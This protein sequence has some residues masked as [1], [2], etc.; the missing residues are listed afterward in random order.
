MDVSRN[1]DFSVNV[2]TRY[3]GESVVERLTA[4]TPKEWVHQRPIRGGGVVDY[5]P[6][7]YFIERLNECFGFLWS[8]RVLDFKVNENQIVVLGEVSV[9]VPGRT[10][11]REF[12]DGTRE[13]IKFDSVKI[14]KQQFGGAEIKRFSKDDPKGKYKAGDVIDLAD[15][16]KA[17]ATDAMKKCGTQFGMFLDVYGP[18]EAASEAKVSPSQLE[19][20]RLRGE[21]AGMGEEQLQLWVKEQAGK[22]IEELDSFDIM[23]LLPKL[24]DLEKSRPVPGVS[25]SGAGNQAPIE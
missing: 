2:K 19:A 1:E 6:G 25:G 23:T 20:L 24:M 18:R 17:A 16:F 5:V 3:L 9:E 14:V 12:P 4:P 22:K 7:A 8:T 10:I 15:D 21:R 11:V 13:T